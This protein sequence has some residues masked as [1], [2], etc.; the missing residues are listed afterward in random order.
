M[1]ADVAHAWGVQK[2]DTMFLVNSDNLIVGRKSGREASAEM[3]SEVCKALATVACLADKPSYG[4]EVSGKVQGAA[5]A[6]QG[7]YTR[8]YGNPNFR[9][10]QRCHTA[11]PDVYVGE[12]RASNLDVGTAAGRGS[13]TPLQS[14]GAVLERSHF[15][16]VSGVRLKDG[17]FALSGSWI[18][19]KEGMVTAADPETGFLDTHLRLRYHGKA[20]Y[21]LMGVAALE[22]GN[23]DMCANGVSG[24]AAAGDACVKG[25]ACQGVGGADGR[26]GWCFTNPREEQALDSTLHKIQTR[27][28]DD[29]GTASR[30]RLVA[31]ATSRKLLAVSGGGPFF[32]VKK[33]TLQEVRAACQKEGGDLASIHSKLEAKE[34]AAACPYKHCYIGAM[35]DGYNKPFYWM[36]GTPFD[37]TAWATSQP[38]GAKGETSYEK[39]VVWTDRAGG[40][41]HDWGRG[42]D[43]FPGVCRM[44]PPPPPPP[45]P[46]EWGGCKP[47]HK[48]A[49]IKVYLLLDGVPVPRTL[50]GKDVVEDAFGRTFV[51]VLEPRVYALISDTHV[52]ARGLELLPATEGV[53]INQFSFASNCASDLPPLA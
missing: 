9:D 50:R 15:S 28:E 42:N 24:N 20:A 4:A 41:W 30:G 16:D 11:T 37:Y 22:Q 13:L 6:Q 47:C 43:F 7:L 39:A 18:T 12:A 1:D 51:S 31:G 14:Y 33:G 21:A 40:H 46:V 32:M 17:A 35:R 36:D 8:Y 19:H 49:P 34:A 23:M 27:L 44:P 26:Y 3:L 52:S 53:A 48:A 5:A 2:L 45:P 25:A 10:H 38:N 29:V